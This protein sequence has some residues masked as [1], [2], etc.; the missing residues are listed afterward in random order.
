MS[1]HNYANGRDVLPSE[2][3]SLVQQHYDGLLYS[4]HSR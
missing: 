3:L 1:R 4:K 2:V